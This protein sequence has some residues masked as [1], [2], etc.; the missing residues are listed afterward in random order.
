MK[1]PITYYGGKQKL[2]SLILPNIPQHTVY[3]EPFVGGGAIF[4]AKPP[5]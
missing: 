2:V 4:F 3:V 1:T 5:S